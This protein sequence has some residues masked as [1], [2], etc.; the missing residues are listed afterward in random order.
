M[1]EAFLTWLH[2]LSTLPIYWSR[3]SRV[4]RSLTLLLFLFFSDR[5]CIPTWSNYL[6]VTTIRLLPAGQLILLL[7]DRLHVWQVWNSSSHHSP[8]VGLGKLPGLSYDLVR[9]CFISWHMHS[10]RAVRLFHAP[11]R[12]TSS[13]CFMLHRTVH[14]LWNLYGFPSCR[15]GRRNH[16]IIRE[17]LGNPTSI[18]RLTNHIST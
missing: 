11:T 1:G 7:L 5:F 16:P 10:L 2:S 13:G 3:Q 12:T 18:Y 9:K 14:A 6:L 4:S 15:N 8:H 17:L